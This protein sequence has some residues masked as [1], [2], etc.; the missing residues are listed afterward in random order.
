MSGRTPGGA[1]ASL[2][3]P[4]GGSSGWR[5]LAGLVL[6]ATLLVSCAW[7]LACVHV[8]PDPDTDAYGHYVIARQLLE[9]PF[10]FKIHWVWLP[11][12]HAVLALPV[13][14]GASLDDVRSLNA[15]GAA[16]PPLLLFGALLARPRGPGFLDA[17]LPLLAAL[18]TATCPL[19]MRL[20]TTGQ[21]EVFFCS[22][23]V[24]AAALLACERFGLAAPVLCALAL[25]RYEGWAIAAFVAVVLPLQHRA[26]RRRLGA[27]AL[28]S[29]LLPGAC[30]LGWVTLRRL[31]GEPWLG[32]LLDNQAFAERVI[33]RNPETLGAL[34]GFG[35]YTV[36]I[37]FRVF[38]ASAAL[39]LVGLRRTLREDGVWFVA[40]GACILGFL[41]LSA[42]THSQLGLDRHFL[43]VVPFAAVWIAHGI[44]RVAEVLE[45]AR[46][47]RWARLSLPVT[48][49]LCTALTIGVARRLEKSL[50]IWW[51][52]TRTALQ[53][54]RELAGSQ[55][56]ARTARAASKALARDV[57]GVNRA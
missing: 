44:A 28:A 56:A 41:T 39:A 20:G 2:R 15:L 27:G 19:L 1:G 7:R 26:E 34:G 33:E 24:L 10:N 32:F 25:T 43:A 12:Y 49:L 54:P 50:S 45:R 14:L 3:L 40:P 22:L 46:D 57:H 30:A 21:M 8:G 16:L 4:P 31:G 11:L 52:T 23:L 51:N 29:V 48:L 18:L 55:L 36:S 5:A 53:Q 42:V 37:P 17:G 38:G 47:G 13:W 35:R 9:T 6:G